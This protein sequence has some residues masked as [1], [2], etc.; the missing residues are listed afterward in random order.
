MSQRSATAASAGLFARKGTAVPNGSPRP[1]ETGGPP[2][3][4]ATRR[5]KDAKDPGG[6]RKANGKSRS[7]AE[8]APGSLHTIDFRRPRVLSEPPESPGATVGLESDA[9]TPAADAAQGSGLATAAAQPRRPAFSHGALL[10][11]LAVVC[12]GAGLWYALY[13]VGSGDRPASPAV[14]VQSPAV[15]AKQASPNDA[16]DRLP[17]EQND[18]AAKPAPLSAN[19]GST[20]TAGPAQGAAPQPSF[21]LIR[22]E[23]NGETVIAGREAPDTELILLD[24]GQPIGKVTADWAGEWAFIPDAPLAPGNH[25]FGLVIV[26]PHGT[27]AV[28]AVGRPDKGA[29]LVPPG[30]NEQPETGKTAENAAPSDQP[31]SAAITAFKGKPKMERSYVVQL[32]STTSRHGA[33]QEWL[34]LKRNFPGLLGDKELK[35]NVHQAVLERGGTR[36]RVRTGSFAEKAPARALCSEFRA[37]RQDCLVIER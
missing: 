13:Y 29:S 16:S 6:D 22:I 24:N 21:D 3:L 1:E 27:V 8:T 36:Y 10:A 4:P 30:V 11:M 26:T 18:A 37:K 9:G 23:P 14:Q 15:A 2:D 20:E 7:A 19:S 34:K 17:A 12:F 35:L 33:E 25:E 28:P 32:S 31:L 5:G